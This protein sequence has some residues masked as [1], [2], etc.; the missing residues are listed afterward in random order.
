ME[1][2]NVNVVAELDRAIGV[3]DGLVGTRMDTLTLARLEPRYSRFLGQKVSTL[4]PLIASLVEIAIVEEVNKGA[5]GYQWIRQEPAFP[6]AAMLDGNGEST[7]SGLEVKAWHVLSTEITGRFKESRARLVSKDVRLTVVA[8]MLDHVVWGTPALL[9]V[10]SCPAIEIAEA[11]DYHYYK[12][13]TYLI[14]EP[15][16]TADRTVNLQQSLVEGYR[17]QESN[18]DMIE[19]AEA[20]ARASGEAANDPYTTE[21]ESLVA[22]LMSRYSYRL[23]TNF[24]KIDRV[25]HQGLGQWKAQTMSLVVQGRSV[26]EWVRVFRDLTSSNDS[27]STAAT[28]AVAPLFDE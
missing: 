13:P 14:V 26:E 18:H 7:G 15:G 12:P 16:D 1:Q 28:K 24:A 6:D 22:L 3:V 2:D 8:W 9:G 4:S 19:S 20:L 23:E 17:L 27:R 11:R 21:A 10:F 25:G 5:K